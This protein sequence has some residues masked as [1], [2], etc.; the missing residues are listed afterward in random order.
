MIVD[1]ALLHSFLLA[2]STCA[3]AGIGSC[4][5]STYQAWFSVSALA[6]LAVLA[7]LALIYGISQFVGRSDIRSW[8]RVKIYDVMLSLLLIFAFLFAASL[9]YGT[10]L[11]FLNTYNL[12]PNECTGAMGN[13]YSLSICDM[14]Q[15]NVFTA[16][17]NNA[18][19][20]FVL[21][22]VSLQP[23][24]NIRIDIPVAGGSIGL[25]A[26]FSFYPKDTGFK[27]LGPAI[28]FIYA[29]ALANDV[30]LIMLSASALIFAILMSLGLVARIFGVSRTF[31]GAMI[32]FALGLG[33]VFPA[34]VCMN[35]GF[36]NYG[37]DQAQSL[38]FANGA[39]LSAIWFLP[40]LVTTYT[41]S[42]LAGLFALGGSVYTTTAT[43][44]PE[45]VFI[46]VGLVWIG[47]TLI[48]LINLVIVDVF[49]VDFSQAIGE[50]MDL[51]SML[52]R[53]L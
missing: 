52:E 29:F 3:A 32:A 21:V 34:L 28:D 36:I 12:V 27:Y 23:S 42:G 22:A 47:L 50:R 35:Y 44:V 51:L 49:I 2:T 37:L 6:A 48:P 33:V 18:Q 24:Y 40:P 8:T 38:A 13:I 15:F 53:I 43:T 19:Y 17:L 20:Y 45:P 41:S 46:Y 9:I 10:N 31:G 39:A 14:Y 7:V 16:N 5:N 25:A 30:Q 11:N 4:F 26:P 1:L